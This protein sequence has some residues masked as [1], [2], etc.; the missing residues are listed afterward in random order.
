[1]DISPRHV[2]IAVVALLVA[3]G[4][5]AASAPVAEP[6][7]GMAAAAGRASAPYPTPGTGRTA[8]V[9]AAVAAVDRLSAARPAVTVSVAVLDRATGRFASNAAGT[10]PMYSASV[11]KIVLAVDMLQRRAVSPADLALLRR[12]LGPSDD[13]AMNVL[14]TRLDGPSAVSRVARQLGL[15]ATRPP[16]NPSQWGQAL[17]SARDMVVVFRH[18]LDSMP[19]ADR[20]LIMGTLAGA[21]PIAADGFNQAFGLMAAAPSA[22]AKQGWMCCV[23]GRIQLQSVGT[24]GEQRRFVVALLSSHPAGRGHDDARKIVNAAAD[25]VRAALS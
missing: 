24:L 22:A 16:A 25:A 19:A 4:C 15:T 17:V 11:I 9:T 20:E 8:S 3:V 14:W 7:T 6:D 10:K 13:K 21:P 12:A 1:V 23:D 2:R 5:A 18:I